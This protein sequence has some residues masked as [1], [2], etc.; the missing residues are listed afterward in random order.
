MKYLAAAWWMFVLGAGLSPAVVQAI[1]YTSLTGMVIAH[2]GILNANKKAD[3][4]NL[5]A[6]AFDAI[7]RIEGAMVGTAF[8]A[9]QVIVVERAGGPLSAPSNYATLGTPLTSQGDPLQLSQAGSFQV[10]DVRIPFPQY[11]YLIGGR[12]TS[13]TPPQTAI[14]GTLSLLFDYFQSTLDLVVFGIDVASPTNNPNSRLFVDFFEADGSV[15]DRL[16][17]SLDRAT[18]QDP[19]FQDFWFETLGG[20]ARI[21]G[22]TLSSS[23]TSGV[24]FG[25]ISF[26]VPSPSAIA[27]LTPGILFLAFKRRRF[28][29]YHEA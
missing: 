11:E 28:T 9:S 15:L 26:F 13:G 22:I 17:I 1:Q 20:D 27:L 21:K 16:T 2:D 18:P 10:L 29:T 7:Q 14:T 23:D 8:D 25:N 6:G 3:F 4:S 12:L 24:V 19:N 5:G